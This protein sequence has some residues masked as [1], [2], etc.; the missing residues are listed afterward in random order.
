MPLAPKH[1]KMSQKNYAILFCL[2]VLIIIFF[3]AAMI[4]FGATL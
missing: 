2:V 3:G 1:K 4:K